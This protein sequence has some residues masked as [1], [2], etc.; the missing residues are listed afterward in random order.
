MAAAWG[1]E[2]MRVEVVSMELGVQVLP[3]AEARWWSR[4]MARLLIV[5]VLLAGVTAAVDKIAAGMAA[6]PVGGLVAGGLGAGFAMWAYAMGV[7]ATERRHVMELLP[8]REE[9]ASLVWRW[10]LA[11]LALFTV[12]IGV[13]AVVGGYRVTGWGSPGGA[14]TVFGTMCAVAVVEELLFRGALFRIVEEM[15][16]T[17][18]ALLVS[19][20]LF[21]ALHLA[22]PGATGWG[23]LAIAVEAGLMLGAAYAAT[24][25]LWVPIG[26]H[27]GWN[28]AEAGLFGVTVS[29]SGAESHGLLEAT[30]SG[31]AALT[32][33]AFGPEAS[34][35]AILVCS[36]PTVLFLRLAHRRGHLNPRP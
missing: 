22:N 2:A 5:V 24:R 6:G 26:L 9:A 30:M 4:P 20:G 33:G 16:G 32:G 25:S 35:V 21:G 27:L 11:G 17:W 29:G 28:A 7:R 34:V 8:G 13:I 10:T 1:R 23:A 31:P 12:T 3:V 15:A 19:G 18:G 36:V 14:V